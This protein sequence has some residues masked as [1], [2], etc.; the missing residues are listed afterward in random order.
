LTKNPNKTKRT[1]YLDQHG[2][3]KNQVDGELL[4][5]HLEDEGWTLCD[6]PSISDLIIINSCGFI[7]SAKKESLESL[8]S[9]RESY[10]EAKI[11]LAGC[12]A[13]RYAEDFAL[14]L[15]EAD[16]IFGNGDLIEIKNIV[17]ELFPKEAQN[18]EEFGALVI[19]PLQEGVCTGS[20]TKLL[21]FPGSAY[22]K[23]TEGCNNC[24]TFCA[25]P[26]IRGQL[27][28]RP[29]ED[30]F[31][32][33]SDFIENGVFEINLIGQDLASY[34]RGEPDKSVFIN[35]ET[36]ASNAS[37]LFHLLSK[38]STLTGNFWIRLL[39]I[40]PDNFPLDILSVIK[41]DSRILPY[42]DIPF[43]SGDEKIIAAMNRH[44]SPSF[45]RSLV[46]T[47]R[48]ECKESS[49]AD[50][51]IRTTFLCGFPGETDEAAANTEKFLESIKP[52]WSGCFVYSKEEDTKAFS[53]KPQVPKK[54]AHKRMNSLI[55]LQ[56]GITKEA[57]VRH[58]GKVFQVLVEELIEDSTGN[59]G[60]AIG[61]AWFQAPEVDGACV[62]RYELDD[63]N[64]VKAVQSG[65]V[66]SVKVIGST[67][68]D[69]DS[70]FI[71]GAA[72]SITT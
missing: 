67:D 56:Q 21:N 31:K 17:K 15:K 66:V 51:T 37:P 54:T 65:Q 72:S 36:G 20:R 18:E 26:L 12:L 23:I 69:I 61:R 71:S 41:K 7:E 35:T 5:G 46:Q 38:L 68:V 22:V 3:A 52:D 34:G 10:P 47:I 55:D 16:G 28:S 62:I 40:H 63:E 53:L 30:I 25:I 45:Y 33:V 27:R 60:L 1:F 42:F 24:C 57:L 49:Y 6:D 39:Y 48:D 8:I 29:I 9:A 58:T 44:N 50:C 14:D 43:Q 4:I 70:V 19:R 2:C 64:A 32:E 59:E 11:I 13:E